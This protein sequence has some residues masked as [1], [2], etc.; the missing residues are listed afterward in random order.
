[1][2]TLYMHPLASYC[3]KVLIALYESRTPFRA[4]VVDFLDAESS[5][6]FKRLWP[7]GKFPLLRDEARGRTVAESTT[8]L[9]Y[10]H[11]HHPGQTRLIPADA[12]LALE[13]RAMDR[14]FDL[15]IHE[16]MQKV[17]DDRLR[18]EEARDALGVARARERLRVAYGV[19]EGW[20]AERPWAA[21]EEFTLA[22]CAAAPALY[23]ADRVEALTAFPRVG[24]YL[25]RLKGRASFVRVLEE[26]GPYLHMFPAE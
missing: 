14:F 1:M 13:A 24:A 8:I 3:W 23:Y 25:Q 7:I 21:G 5:A 2:L 6:A 17:V 22:D 15:H 12:S 16:H 10:L 18:P 9:E 26:A 11:L 4:H 20:M 19:L